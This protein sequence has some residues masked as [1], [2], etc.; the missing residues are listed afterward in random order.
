MGATCR[1]LVQDVDSAI[2]TYVEVFGFTLVQQM[3]PAFAIVERGG[4]VLWLSGPLTSAAKP[5]PDGAQ[6][7]PGGWNRIVLVTDDIEAEIVTILALG[8][9]LRGDLVRGPGGAQVVVNDGQ[10]NL[11]EIFQPQR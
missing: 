6:P 1:Y 7:V 11:V 2:K 5:M 8:V 9:T 4:L 3:G 10:G